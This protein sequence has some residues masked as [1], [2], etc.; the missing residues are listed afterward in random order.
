MQVVRLRVDGL[1]DDALETALRQRLRNPA[2]DAVVRLRIEGKVSF[3]AEAV[4]RPR[5]LRE[6]A[7]S[8]MIV[9]PPRLPGGG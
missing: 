6:L 3:G 2:S 8:T 4:L 9:E 5:R 7:P 1:D